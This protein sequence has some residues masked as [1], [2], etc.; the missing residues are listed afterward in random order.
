MTS[1]RNKK[2]TTDE[3]KEE[4]FKLVGDEYTVVGEYIA[5][6]TKIGMLHKNC[7]EV[8]YVRPSS[9]LSGTRCPSCSQR[10]SQD[11]FSTEIHD[12]TNGEFSV[13]GKYTK[14]NE[15]VEFQHNICNRTFMKSPTHFFS[16]PICPW[17]YKEG[18]TKNNEQFLSEFHNL[19]GNEYEVLGTYKNNKTPI[20]IKHIECGGEFNA[21]PNNLLTHL[22]RCPYCYGNR[23]KDT[24]TFKQE[25][26]KLV[27]DE[28]TILGE[29]TNS[30]TKISIRHNACGHEYSVRPEDFTRS[31]GRR[32]PI[33]S[34]SGTSRLE[35]ELSDY[36]KSIYK[37]K[38]IN[39]DTELLD[40]KE[41]DIYLPHKN[42]A[43]EFDGLYWHSDD[44]R[45]KNYHIKKT[46]LSHDKGV[47]LIHIFEDEWILHR[48]LVKN[49]IKHIL[50]LS[51]PSEKIYARKCSIREITISEKDNFLIKNH[52]QGKD[53]SSIK[54]G[55]FYDD[56][57]VAVMTFGSV[58][59]SVGGAENGISHELIRFASDIDK[60]VVGG[61]GKLLAYFKK[62]YEWTGIKTFADIRWSSLDDTVYD[63]VGFKKKHISEPN[64]WYFMPSSL[65][66]YHRYSFR[67]NVL[68]KK[69][70]NFDKSKTEV[71]NMKDNG[72][73]RIWDC[74]NIVYEI[75]KE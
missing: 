48:D 53:K 23:R 47:R 11:T 74:G 58:R 54:L 41:L 51:T 55:L 73:L 30:S 42:I 57:L 19:W 52:I 63:K 17:C 50:N 59:K 67:K 34:N 5:T 32:C 20:L 1:K 60:N 18:R 4:V 64:Y 29:Y 45:D 31:D 62:N 36:I 44:Y 21:T 3:Y 69:I 49:K 12:L 43:F 56:T 8:W 72:W 39:N 6:K 9:F 16:R 65:N 46:M 66:R 10:K 7:G 40:G 37:G 61:F 2:R 26:H 35:K 75:K 22:T 38:I 27:G 14:N 13:I 24:D 15:K 25:V 70:K 28:Y 33:C 71:E 68:S